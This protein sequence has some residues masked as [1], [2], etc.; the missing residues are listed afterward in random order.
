MDFTT[1]LLIAAISAG[2]PLLLATLGGILNERAGIIQLGAEGLMLMGA[3]I[4]CIVYIR[5]ESVV[6][7]PGHGGGDRSIS[8]LY[9][10]L[11]HTG[12]SDDV[13]TCNDF[14]SSGLSAW[15]GQTISGIRRRV[16]LHLT[17]PGADS[18]NR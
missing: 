7:L 13:R 11:C 17:W 4:T 16:P 3:V 6:A 9:L 8:L 12:E 1:Q 15:S 18:G 10:F 5:R 14:F 2:T